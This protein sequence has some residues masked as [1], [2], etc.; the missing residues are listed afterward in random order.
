M[1][2]FEININLSC[3][4]D[5]MSGSWNETHGDTVNADNIKSEITSWLEDLGFTVDFSKETYHEKVKDILW[6]YISE[7]D[8]PEIAERL[9]N[10][11]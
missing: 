2:T 11:V 10:E 9:D 6:E 7:K 1:K 4:E 3:D 5:R 8:I